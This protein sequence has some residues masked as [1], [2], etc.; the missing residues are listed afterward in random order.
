MQGRIYSVHIK[1]ENSFPWTCPLAERWD[2]VIPV[3]TMLLR[4]NDR[5]RSI[6]FYEYTIKFNRKF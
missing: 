5:L 4:I 1:K 6:F 3:M 2:S